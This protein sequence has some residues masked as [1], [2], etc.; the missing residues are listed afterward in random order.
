MYPDPKTYLTML[1][2]LDRTLPEDR[3]A[4]K[5]LETLEWFSSINTKLGGYINTRRAAVASWDF[6]LKPKSNEFVEA[7]QEAM[8]RLR[9]AL[10]VIIFASVDLSL[11]GAFCVELGWETS[12]ADVTPKTARQLPLSSLT[13]FKNDTVFEFVNDVRYIRGEDQFYIAGSSP[14]VGGQMRSVGLMEIYRND[15]LLEWLNFNRKLKGIIHGIEHGASAEE[16]AE[17]KNA[18]ISAVKNNYLMTSDL[19]DFNFH[20]IVQ[21]GSASSFKDASDLLDSSIA[22]A[23]VG[24]ANVAELP[25]KTGSRAALQVQKLVTDDLMWFDLKIAEKA[26][27]KLVKWDWFLNYG[28][29]SPPYRFNFITDTQVDYESN[30]AVIR[31]ALAAGI[32]LA[33]T[34]V[35]EKIGF[36]VPAAGDEIFDG[37]LPQ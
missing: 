25:A 35:Y 13:G 1:R 20:S 7:A 6:D 23:I 2:N 29:E 31:E 27:N 26:C 5:L 9:D 34:E 10:Q 14:R 4:R 28:N 18:L 21:S 22:I 30:V 19:V 17:A 15:N 12:E 37:A 11:F 36:K 16:I 32:P 3:D 33:K 8:E 24:Q